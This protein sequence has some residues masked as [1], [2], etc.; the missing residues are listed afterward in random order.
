M[1]LD[2]LNIE[3]ATSSW[4]GGAVALPLRSHEDTIAHK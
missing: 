3:I 4:H 1:F 2:E